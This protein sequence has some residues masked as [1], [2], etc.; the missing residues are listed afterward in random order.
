MSANVG[1]FQRLADILDRKPEVLALPQGDH[2]IAQISEVALRDIFQLALKSEL[3]HLEP[4]HKFLASLNESSAPV[5]P[6]PPTPLDGLY[7][8]GMDPDQ[9][10]E[11]LELRNVKLVELLED[12]GAVQSGREPG[13]SDD[14]GSLSLEEKIE[15]GI[16]DEDDEDDE[17][18]FDEI[19][20]ME[21]SGDS[22]E[23]SDDDEEDEDSEEVEED[24]EEQGEED[25]FDEEDMEG[26]E[27]DDEEEEEDEDDDTH[28]RI[29]DL[30]EPGYARA[31][32]KRQHPSLDDEFFSIDDFNRETE[33]LEAFEVSAGKLGGDDDDDEDEEDDDDDLMGLSGGKSGKADLWGTIEADEENGTDEVLYSDFFGPPPK[34][35]SK[36]PTSAPKKPSLLKG[37]GK[38][39]SFDDM[40][41]EDMMME[42]Q[43]QEDEDGDMD[44][45]NEENFEEED[46]GEF[47]EEEEDDDDARDVTTRAKGDLFAD[48]SEDEEDD[49]PMSTHAKRLAALSQQIAA[50][51]SENAAPKPWALAGEASSKSRPIN[52]ILEEDL[53]FETV[54]KQVPIVTEE[55]VKGLEDKIKQRILDNDFNDVTRL[56][57]MDSKPFLPSRVFELNDEKSAKSLAQIYEDD[58]TASNEK[59]AGRTPVMNEKDS[60]LQ[61]QHNE[62]ETLWEEICYKLDAL[63]NANFTPKQPKAQIKTISNVASLSLESALPPTQRASHLLAPEE[64]FQP[65]SASDLRAKSEMTPAEKQAARE[66][67]KKRKRKQREMLVG[68]AD[69]FEKFK[70]AGKRIGGKGGDKKSKDEALRTLVKEGRGITVIGKDAK[71][72]DKKG[73]REGQPGGENARQDG[74]F[75]KL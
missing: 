45:D 44:E 25:M 37:K 64:V 71:K 16:I 68:K 22:E 2:E 69:S 54:G 40:D 57:A 5:E 43:D 56:R 59:A 41:D 29:Q 38:A 33:E 28:K 11:Q 74:S 23:G 58:Y 52:A 67:D 62:I 15:R 21:D 6:V 34:I 39:S 63:S 24:G 1:S 9:I 51:E 31:S 55:K 32:R 18:G 12:V 13:E 19:D 4:I 49:A 20:D 46:E 10:W 8:E 26:L 17:L 70:H 7:T 66:K 36:K 27:D 48:D 35:Y 3:T 14:E 72:F 60:K 73:R 65:P 53:D 50:L 75:L 42:D 30:D 61:Q 47:S